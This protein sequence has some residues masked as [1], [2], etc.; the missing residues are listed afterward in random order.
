LTSGVDLF[1]LCAKREKERFNNPLTFPPH[2]FLKT[3]RNNIV[4]NQK[5]T[6]IGKNQAP[7]LFVAWPVTYFSA[8][9]YLI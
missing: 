2:P 5:F 6:K 7:L 4:E 8:I 1:Y 3:E 9:I